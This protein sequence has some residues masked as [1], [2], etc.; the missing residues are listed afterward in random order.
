MIKVKLCTKDKRSLISKLAQGYQHALSSNSKLFDVQMVDGKYPELGYIDDY[1]IKSN[2][3]PY[4]IYLEDTPIGFALV[5]TFVVNPD[6]HWKLAE[7]YIAQEHHGC[8]YGRMAFEQIKHNHDG[9]WELSVF[10]DNDKALY[11]WEAVLPTAKNKCEY[12]SYPN[13]WFFEF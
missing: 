12:K 10:K 4:I 8:G 2:R 11:F 7:F 9:R 5:H 13:Y 3:Y 1:W 6:N